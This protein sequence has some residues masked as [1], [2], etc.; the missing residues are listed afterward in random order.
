M[1]QEKEIAGSRELT[2]PLVPIIFPIGVLEGECNNTDI[3]AISS[4]EARRRKRA[5]A[6][7]RTG[8]MVATD[9][10]S[11]SQHSDNRLRL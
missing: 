8:C 11:S 9:I 5:T 7:T 6:S 4:P 2:F 1:D 10:R 3:H